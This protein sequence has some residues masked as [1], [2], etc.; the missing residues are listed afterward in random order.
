MTTPTQIRRYDHTTRSGCRCAL[1]I[2]GAMPRH[3]AD[4]EALRL[5]WKPPRWWQWWRRHDQPRKVER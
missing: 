2:V 1:V 3:V 4:A 5:G